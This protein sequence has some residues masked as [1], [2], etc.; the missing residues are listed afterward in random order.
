MKIHGILFL[1]GSLL[2]ADFTQPDLSI[3][4]ESNIEGA[5]EAAFTESNGV[6]SPWCF[7][8]NVVWAFSTPA[9]KTLII[10]RAGRQLF[11]GRFVI[12]SDSRNIDFSVTN[13]TANRPGIFKIAGDELFI[14][15]DTSKL[16]RRPDHL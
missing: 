9:R 11:E 12:G 6:R 16:P 2:G 5:W 7:K 14:C 3:R 8:E 1:L 10:R 13:A 15:E 4:Q